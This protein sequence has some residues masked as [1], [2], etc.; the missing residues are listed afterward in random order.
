MLAFY[1]KG[2]GVVLSPE[3][4]HMSQESARPFGWPTFSSPGT[5]ACG[6]DDGEFG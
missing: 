6:R 3:N 5:A 1:L 2:F 4:T